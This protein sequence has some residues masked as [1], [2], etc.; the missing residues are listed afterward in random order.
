[1]THI[2]VSDD[3]KDRLEAIGSMGDTH[4]DVVEELLDFYE[5]D[6]SGTTTLNSQ[7]KLSLGGEKNGDRPIRYAVKFLDE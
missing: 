6:L 2:R 7:A 4:D 1:M 5:A 3:T